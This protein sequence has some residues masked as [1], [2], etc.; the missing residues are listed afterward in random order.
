MLNSRNEVSELRLDASRC[1]ALSA[2]VS[3]TKSRIVVTSDWREVYSD[4][5]MD[6]IL[7]AHGIGG[8]LG[9]TPRGMSSREQAI[10]SSVRVLRPSCW[11]ALDDMILK[12]GR[13]HFVRC[14]PDAGPDWE[15][16]KAALANRFDYG[17]A[18]EVAVP[19]DDSKSNKKRRAVKAH[20]L[21][22]RLARLRR[23]E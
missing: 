19:A 11:V 18:F 7:R 16:V 13:E 10:L 2:F 14:S 5:A 3:S 15:Q 1:K 6:G 21:K 8:F 23:G 22:G 4:E 17:G 20:V 9:C 12:I